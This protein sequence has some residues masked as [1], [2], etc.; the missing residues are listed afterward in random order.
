MAGSVTA[1]R[2]LQRDTTTCGGSASAAPP[3]HRGSGDISG[4]L[5]ALWGATAELAAECLLAPRIC[6]AAGRR[7]RVRPRSCALFSCFASKNNPTAS[8][9]PLRAHLTRA[10]VR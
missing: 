3:G 7:A 5:P 10:G 4:V 8:L 2:K 9:L 1:L 6:A